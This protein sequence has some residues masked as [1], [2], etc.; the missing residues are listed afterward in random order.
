MGKEHNDFNTGTTVGGKPHTVPVAPTFKGKA[1]LQVEEGIL[2]CAF[3]Y[4]LGRRTSAVEEVA[5]ELRAHRLSLSG[6]MRMMI[7]KEINDALRR[8]AAGAE[9]DVA[10]WTKTRDYILGVPIPENE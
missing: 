9:I 8:S 7:V 3:R 10:E 1:M 2:F 4:A 6:K 5:S